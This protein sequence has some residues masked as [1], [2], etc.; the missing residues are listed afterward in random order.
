ML[1]PHVVCSKISDEVVEASLDGKVQRALAELPRAFRVVV[2]LADIEGHAYREIVAIHS[3]PVGTAMWC[4][5]RGRRFLERA[6]L[7]FGVRYNYL[8]RRPRRLRSGDLDIER[9][10][11]VAAAPAGAGQDIGRVVPT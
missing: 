2:L 5:Y 3:I 7:F 8:I 11:G 10:F 1:Q 4:L 6:L 9:L